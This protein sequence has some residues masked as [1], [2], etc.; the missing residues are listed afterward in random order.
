MISFITQ[1][2]TEEV[3]KAAVLR[4]AT[5]VATTEPARAGT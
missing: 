5:A 2:V 3:H 4:K 1:I